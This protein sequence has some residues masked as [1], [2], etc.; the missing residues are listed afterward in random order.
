MTLFFFLLLGL[1]VDA[2]EFTLLF[3]I[4]AE[5][6]AVGNTLIIALG[7]AF[8]AGFFCFVFSLCFLIALLFPFAFCFLLGVAFFSTQICDDWLVLVGVLRLD[9]LEDDVDADDDESLCAPQP[10]AG[11]VT[12]R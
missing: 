2:F 6:F 5:L 7:L 3:M 9:S 8:L 12:S 1:D 4:F 10:I 11:G